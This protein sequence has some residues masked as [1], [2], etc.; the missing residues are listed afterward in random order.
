VSA[1][2]ASALRPAEAPTARGDRLPLWAV[3]LVFAGPA[4]GDRPVPGTG[5]HLQVI[6]LVCVTAIAVT[7]L[8]TIAGACPSAPRSPAGPSAHRS[9]SARAW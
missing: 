5:G 1:P 6:H 4:V 2:P 9:A 8:W 3:A 7:A